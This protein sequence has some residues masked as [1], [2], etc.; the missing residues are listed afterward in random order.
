MSIVKSFKIFEKIKNLEDNE[1]FAVTCTLLMYL[2]S[3]RRNVL[4]QVKQEM[5][6]LM[7]EMEELD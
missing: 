5:E 4:K 3:E 7:E 6:E 2:K 1:L